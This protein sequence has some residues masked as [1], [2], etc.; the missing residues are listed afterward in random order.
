VPLPANKAAMANS[1]QIAELAGIV[2]YQ[3]AFGKKRVMP[4]GVAA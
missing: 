4:P 3:R 1:R 2:R